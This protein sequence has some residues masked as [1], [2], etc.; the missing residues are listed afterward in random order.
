[1]SLRKLKRILVDGSHTLPGTLNS[2]VQR[3]VRST[4]EHTPSLAADRKTEIIVAD[5]RG[6]F[7]ASELKED[8]PAARFSK[9]KNNVLEHMPR[10]YIQGAEFVCQHIRHRKLRTWL[11][12]KPGHQG[13]FKLPLRMYGNLRNN[14]QK[15]WIDNVGRGDLLLLPDAY[16]A[17]DQVWGPVAAARAKGAFVATIVYD[18]IPLTHPHFV[19]ARAPKSFEH[20]L[21]QAGRHSDLMVAISN[22][23]RDDVR[24]KLPQLLKGEQHC[25]DIR[26]FRLGAEFAQTDGAVREEILEIFPHDARNTPYLMVAT[27]DP[28]KNHHYLLDAFEKIWSRDPSRKLCLIGRIGWLCHDVVERILSHPN[29]GKQ[30]SMFNDISDAEL[31]HCYQKARA[32]VFPSI[33]EGFG[34]PIVE[35]LWHGR[36]VFA[37]DTPIHREVGERNCMYSDL[38]HP[39]HLA[40]Q[41]L[42]WEQ[43]QSDNAPFNETGLKPLSW[44]ESIASLLEICVDS[45]GQN[46]STGKLA[47]SREVPLAAA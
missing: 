16:W 4:V 36:Q 7:L 44:R 46:S 5:T 1:M 38:N 6:F 42:T 13:I 29:Y 47:L 3:V 2:G 20:Y 11:L 45:Y 40:D 22:T 17:H 15:K 34:L 33:V 8:S 25:A 14:M 41:I 31:H 19:A 24:A 12:P 9:L 32:V 30:L 43:G 26:S 18:L 39:A 37:S 35:A 21:K 10:S 23:V 28:R 27:F